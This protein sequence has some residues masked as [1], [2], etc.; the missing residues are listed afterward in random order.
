M[1]DR[2]GEDVFLL[3]PRVLL[4]GGASTSGLGAEALGLLAK[5]A[6]WNM[7]KQKEEESSRELCCR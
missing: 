7:Y 3:L 6:Y 2:V 4:E 5:N 1:A